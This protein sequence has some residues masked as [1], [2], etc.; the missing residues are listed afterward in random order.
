MDVL[1]DT[2]ILAAGGQG[3]PPILQ[4]SGI[5][6]AG[7]GFFCDPLWFVMGP[8]N[9]QGSVFDVPMTAGTIFEE[10]GIVMTDLGVTPLLY[11]ALLGLAGIR[12]WLSLPKVLSTKKTLSIMI[13][14][15]D[16]LDGRINLDESFSKPIDY[17]TWWRLNK[18]AVL[19]EEILMKAGVRR[20]DLVKTCVLAAHPGGTVRIGGLLN[21]HCETQ[22]QNCV[23]SDAS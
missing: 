18:G 3:T 12:G 16:E 15:R 4:R 11:A 20:D 6:D 19:A 2:V 8:A 5:Y 9:H 23:L 10:D 17:D 1:A 7:Q 14:V 21:S 13:K 22:I